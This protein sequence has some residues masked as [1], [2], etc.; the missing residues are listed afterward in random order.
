[1]SLGDV[2]SGFELVEISDLIDYK[3]KGY[4]FRHIATGMEVFQVAND[5][6]ELFFGYAFRTM[7]SNDCGIA[8]ILEHSVLAGSKK[9][10]VRD[11]FMSLLKGSTNTYMNALT[12][13][14]KTLYPAASPLPEDFDNLFSVYTDAVFA[15]LLREETFQ[16]EGVR[17]VAD[18][19]GCHF[20]GVVFNEMLGDGADHDSIVGRQSVRVL[21]PDTLYAFESGGIPEEIVKLDYQQ[22]LSFYGQFYHPSNCRLFLYGNL[23]IGAKLDYLEREYLG[24]CGMIKVDRTL[25]VSAP[26]TAPRRNTFTSPVEEGEGAGNSSAVL[27]WATTDA[28]DPLEVITLS[29]LVDILLGNPGAP[30]YKALL[31]SGL[32]KDVSPESGMS[33]EFPQMPFVVGFKGIEPEKAAEA[34]KLILS[35]LKKLSGRGIEKK[36]VK[37]AMKRAKFKQQEIPGGIPMGIRALSRALRGWMTGHSPAS[38]IGTSEPLHALEAALEADDR[39][40]EHWI[41]KNL[42][43][44]R[45]R[46][47]VVV[48]PDKDHQ[49]R[50][51][52]AIARYARQQFD[53]LG[54]K[55]LKTLAEQNAKFLRFEQ[56]GDSPEALA[57]VPR[58]HLGD[59]PKEIRKNVHE[60]SVLEG[61]DLYYHPRFCNNIVYADL[62]IELCDLTERQL[63]LMPLYLRVL[64]MTGLKQMDYPQVANKLRHL[65]GDFNISLE[66][67]SSMGEQEDRYLALARVKTLQEDFA[68]AMKFVGELL[69]GAKVGDEVRVKAALSDLK[70]DYVD[71]VTYSAHGFAAV[72]A[73]SVM[74][75]VQFAG[76]SLSGLRQ[77]LFLETLDESSIPSLA[78]ELVEL[79]K[80]LSNRNR[81]TL[82]LTADRAME[83]RASRTL[84]RFV[85][86][87][88]EGEVPRSSGRH[89]AA[90]ADAEAHSVALY[91][92]PSTVSYAAYVMRSSSR[93]S[94]SQAAQAV[95]GQII[96][97]NDLWELVRGQ[98]GAY[99]VSAHADV[100]EQLFLFT[101][102][103]DPRIAG[104]FADFRRVLEKYAT[105]AIDEKDIENALITT[106]GDDLKPL[107]PAQEDILGFRRIL[108]GISDD[109]R[110]MRREQLLS[111][112]ADDLNK[113]AGELLENAGE[114]DSYVVLAGGK[115]LEAE[116]AKNAMLDRPSV[117]LP[118]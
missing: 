10:P 20:E 40:F 50:Q 67:G 27:S 46:S 97:G 49:A 19:N 5:D 113:A 30:L 106:V 38:T 89:Y 66:T 71:N 78:A 75:D 2:V 7:P 3:A 74:G 111:L 65:T 63:L 32:G 80:L 8:H 41:R 105:K 62:A 11:P 104:T 84:Q 79:Q 77:W 73:A 31:D 116:K 52:N 18:E 76:D 87:F 4:L 109:F 103:R 100:L 34:E 51:L 56:E 96:S 99:G 25:P 42:L 69:Q 43:D 115:L 83:K 85:A 117:R 95:L 15:P 102:Y 35:V 88:P 82:H 16:Q 92:L 14:D 59:L 108:Y 53:S 68:A 33:A 70:T 17:L 91:R 101:S 57:T 61:R 54:K 47:L 110:L 21:F 112:V 60:R 81:F 12:Y 26:W 94:R 23:E 107:S 36:I 58:L 22:F 64:Q 9:Y 44:N 90:V 48:V 114:K 28:N 86:A 98:G 13:P 93:G 39:Y 37:A 24:T 1:M 45:H 72:S 6:P 29:T 55:G 118:L